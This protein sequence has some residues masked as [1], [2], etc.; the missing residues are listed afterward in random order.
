MDCTMPFL[1]VCFLIQ[2]V[3]LNVHQLMMHLEIGYFLA[4]VGDH[5]CTHIDVRFIIMETVTYIQQQQ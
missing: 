2:S 5:Y 4:A 1:N 3:V